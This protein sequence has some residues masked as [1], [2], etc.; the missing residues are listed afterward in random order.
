V[1]VTTG[2]GAADSTG[3]GAGVGAELPGAGAG[4]GDGEGL[5]DG[6]G[7]GEGLGLGEGDGDGL[8]LGGGGGGGGGGD[9]PSSDSRIAQRCVAHDCV[10]TPLA[11]VP[12]NCITAPIGVTL[13]LRVC[14]T[15]T[16]PACTAAVCR[17]DMSQYPSVLLPITVSPS[18]PVTVVVPLGEFAK[19][20][21]FVYGDGA[22]GGGG[23]N[24]TRMPH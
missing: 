20:Y 16:S 9:V 24:A 8:G 4:A 1:P 5:G 19:Q 12:V 22:G 3:A 10:V 11:V 23:A 7:A 15:V 6:E 17:D 14:P 18:A 13:T 21:S 2:A